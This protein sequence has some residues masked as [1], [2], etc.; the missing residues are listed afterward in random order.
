MVF[1]VKGIDMGVVNESNYGFMRTAECIYRYKNQLIF[2]TMQNEKIYIWD[3]D[4]DYWTEIA[5]LSSESSLGWLFVTCMELKGFLYF[6]PYMA[7]DMIGY[8][9]KTKKFERIPICSES[10]N[11]MYHKASYYKKNM[12]LF[13]YIGNEILIYNIESREIKRQKICIREEMVKNTLFSNIYVDGHQVWSVT[14]TDSNVLCYNMEQGEYNVYAIDGGINP[15]IDITGVNDELFLLTSDG[16]VMAWNM[17]DKTERLIKK[18]D[19]QNRKFYFAIR[20]SFDRLWLIPRMEP[21]IKAIDLYGRV[22]FEWDFSYLEIPKMNN[23]FFESVVQQE[24]FLFL[25]SFGKGELVIINTRECSVEVKDIHFNLVEKLEILMRYSNE[26]LSNQS[27]L[28]GTHIWN[29][30]KKT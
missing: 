12:Y 28:I 1:R 30:T 16:I 20:Y 25:S 23:C 6:I 9:L 2:Y 22:V 4:T 21:C 29:Q 14:G 27:E 10:H 13:P 19:E 11:A 17:K 15:I 26:F 3:K 8:H 24:D 18:C 5:D 7:R